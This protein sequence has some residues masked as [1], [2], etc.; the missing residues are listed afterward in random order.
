MKI[1]DII[2]HVMEIPDPDGHTPRRNWI[3]VE[4]RTDEGL[5]GIG[6]ATTEYT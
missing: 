1:T 5:T 4:I 3:F 2:A 6:E